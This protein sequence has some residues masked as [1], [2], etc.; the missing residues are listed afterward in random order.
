[1][2]FSN[3]EALW[4]LWL[5]P[6]LAGLFA[7]ASRRRADA[8]ARFADDAL[9]DHLIHRPS[10]LRAAIRPT[11]LGLALIAIITAAAGPRW[12][13]Q[14]EDVRRHGV[15][16]VVALDLS[17]SMLAEDASPDRLTAAKRE[18]RDL[19][20]LLEGDRIGLVVF[21]GVS[22]VQCPLTLD[23]GAF[24]VFLDPMDP[25]WVPV[26]GTD[27]AA[28]VRSAVEAFPKN[29]RSGRA[30]LLIT[31]GEDHSGELQDAAAEAKK[32]GVH[33]FVVGMGA[34]E[35]APVPDGRG[36][37]VKEGGRVVLSKLDEASLKELALTTGGSYVRS[38]AGDL[39]LQKIYLEDIKGT[40]EARELSSSRQR[41]WEERFQ[42]A[43]LPAVLLLV[44][45]GMVGAPRRR[46]P[47]RGGRTLPLGLLLLTTAA[48]TL[49]PRPG[50]AEVDPQASSDPVRDGHKAFAQGNFDEALSLWIQAQVD[51][52][53]DPR[54]D[55][56]IGEAHYRLGNFPDAESAFR[57][58]TA[59]DRTG[60]AADG[61]YN[62]GNAAFQ[63]GKYLE[64][65]ALY[66]SSLE[67]RAEDEDA[68]ANRDL[69]Q[70]KHEEL[71][72]Q[73]NQDQEEPPEQQEN[74]DPQQEEQD[75]ESDEQM[76]AEQSEDGE[77]QQNQQEQQE[78]QAANEEPPPDQQDPAGGEEDQNSQDEEEPP[79]ST[80][81]AASAADIDREQ[82][83]GDDGEPED[84]AVGSTTEE[85]A[86][87]DGPPR[88][89]IEGA[90]SQEQA[91][92]LLRALEEDQ[93]AR[94]RERTE[95]ER[96]RGR[97]GAAKDW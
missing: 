13:F 74:P 4:L 80:G 66:E 51:D 59:T 46:R 57:A 17:R 79:P 19:L 1:M 67:L 91:E 48:V 97:R 56:N 64:A 22:F 40:L 6:L 52:P 69:A 35:G 94:R 5:V 65:V 12:G 10:R 86:P 89:A 37:F 25:D 44:L 29:E 55:Y 73:A 23:Y 54:L 84:G 38:I 45:E 81:G 3:P 83:P 39:D 87:Q 75:P 62:A 32:E 24:S 71:L 33:V 16:I 2:H 7:F 76:P 15:D 27:L 58:A 42:L 50:L 30:V 60:L 21:A 49:A 96:K 20:E 92:A 77:G 61:F 93:A 78:G 18:I 31:D 68:E 95:R 26:G 9:I 82:D 14:W 28:A 85:D 47:R 8:L 11:L 43:L 63:Q 90:L 70:R 36:G 34:P 53:T 41:R 72:E 88:E